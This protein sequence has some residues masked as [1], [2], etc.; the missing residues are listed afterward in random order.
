[1]TFT[2]VDLSDTHTVTVT[3]VATSGA[4]SGLPTTATMLSWFS[5]GALTDT[6]G[7]GLGGS[8]AWSFSA[9]DK[10][11]DYPGGGPDR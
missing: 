1:M 5:L 7:T 9:Q 6:T 8:D 4:T 10:T 11:F 3:G 2:D